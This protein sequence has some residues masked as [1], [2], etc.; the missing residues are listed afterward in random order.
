MSQVRSVVGEKA[1]GG[2]LRR[3]VLK[4]RALRGK[5][6]RSGGRRAGGEVRD[7]I[8][9]QILLVHFRGLLAGTLVVEG[10]LEGAVFFL[11]Y[12]NRLAALFLPGRESAFVRA[13]CFRAGLF[14]GGE[15]LG[16][17]SFD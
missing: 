1:L 4:R 8:G 6:L 5:G 3:V 13:L 2:A 11:L 17:A 15:A 12:V 9:K 16:S 10:H 7:F 14:A